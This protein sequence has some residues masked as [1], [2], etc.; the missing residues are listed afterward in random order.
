MLLLQP[1]DQREKQVEPEVGKRSA[2]NLAI[3]EGIIQ[4]DSS[5]TIAVMEE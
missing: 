4:K 3:K 2:S 1:L 5:L